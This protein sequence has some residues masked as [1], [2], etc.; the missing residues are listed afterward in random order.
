MMRLFKKDLIGIDPGAHSLKVVWLRGTSSNASLKASASFRMAQGAVNQADTATSEYTSALG[1][2]VSAAGLR[3]RRAA[4]LMTG[5][6]MIFRHMYLPAMP[7]ADL[8]EAVRWELKKEGV[9]PFDDMVCDYCHASAD[10]R[11]AANLYSIIA[12]AARKS[13]VQSLMDSFKTAGVE[14]R[15]VDTVPTALLFA[16]NANNK[17]ADGVNYGVIDIGH[18]RSTLVILRDRQLAFVREIAFGGADLTAALAQASGRDEAWAEEYK[19][20]YGLAGDAK[21]NGQGAKALATGLE[22]FVTEIH[23][24]FDF[25]KAQFRGGQVSR[26]YVSGATAMLAGIDAYISDALAIPAFVDDPFRNIRGRGRKA[27]AASAA[28]SFSVAFGMAIRMGAP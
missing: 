3:G 17:W 11:A 14:I 13:G 10:G 18:T 21:D 7:D 5:G 26:L 15:V 1:A 6:S 12:F 22:R 20:A 24:S 23:R 25:Y 2:A 9:I 19:L 27:K 8:K 16:F 4:T 28:A